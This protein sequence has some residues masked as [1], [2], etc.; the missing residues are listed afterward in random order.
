MSEKESNWKFAEDI[1]S[2]SEVIAR[3]R[4]HSLELGVEAIT[5]PIG[6]QIGDAYVFGG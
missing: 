2:E 1:V 4:E 5:P 6:A 3:A